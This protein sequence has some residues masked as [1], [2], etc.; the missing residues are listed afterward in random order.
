MNVSVTWQ[1]GTLQI[2]EGFWD[3]E[4]ILDYQGGSNVITGILLS[5]RGRQKSQFQNGS[6]SKTQLDIAGFEDGVKWLQAKEYKQ[7]LKTGKR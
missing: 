6:M 2:N 5:E 3:G 4:L 7:S 1:K